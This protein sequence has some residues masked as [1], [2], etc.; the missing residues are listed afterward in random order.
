M[1]LGAALAAAMP[2]AGAAETLTDTLISAYRNSDLLAQQR[3]V[4]RASDEDVA[5]AVA[6]LRPVIALNGNMT[7]SYRGDIRRH[8][9][10][11]RRSADL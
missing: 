9:V 4:V 3:A 5:Q 2:L 8:P 1:I 10:D 7:D 11:D 6:A